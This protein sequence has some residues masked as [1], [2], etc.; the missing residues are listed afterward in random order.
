[1]YSEIFDT[2]PP[3]IRENRA[4]YPYANP[5]SLRIKR[6]RER[7][8]ESFVTCEIKVVQFGTPGQHVQNSSVCYIPT[9]QPTMFN[10]LQG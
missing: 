1:M 4:C 9:S 8:K 7:E 2:T 6:E 3:P 5:S 10:I